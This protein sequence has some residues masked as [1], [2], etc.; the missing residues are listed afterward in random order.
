MLKKVLF[1]LTLT[2]FPLIS[3]AAAQ[4]Q[5]MLDNYSVAP[6][7]TVILQL[8][9]HQASDRDLRTIREPD[10]SP[11]KP[12]F[13][14][15]QQSRNQLSQIINGQI[16]NQ[17][18]W[19]YVLEPRKLGEIDI[20]PLR[21]KTS[22]GYLSSQ[23]LTIRVTQD[24]QKRDNTW[25][26]AFV[27]KE[28]PYL[29]EP[30]YYTLRV[31]HPATVKEFE[32]HPPT[33]NLLVEQLTDLHTQR[34][35]KNN[36]NLFVSEVTYLLTPLRSGRLDLS[37]GKMR[38]L[39]ASSQN[40]RNPG[41]M[42]FNFGFQQYKPIV[43]TSDPISLEVKPPPVNLPVWLPLKNLRVE[44]TWETALK[45]ATTVGTP[46]IRTLSLVGEGM[47]GQSFPDLT[48]LLNDN[49]NFRVRSP[50]PE[51]ERKL[52][53]DQKTPATFYTQTF[54]LIPLKTGQ[55]TLDAI[56]IPWWDVETDQLKWAEIPAQSFTVKDNPHHNLNT[57]ANTTNHASPSGSTTTT[58]NH[59]T[60]HPLQPLS[61]SLL[62]AATLA[63]FIGLIQIWW[64]RWHFY[65]TRHVNKTLNLKNFKNQI[66]HATDMKTL[67]ML[68]QNYAQT[69]WQL[70]AYTALS[71]I[72]LYLQKHYDA[73]E[74]I[75][76]QLQVL[77]AALYGNRPI[78]L[79]DWKQT[80]L[81]NF[82]QLR[83]KTSTTQAA[84]G[85]NTALNPT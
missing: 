80:F 62:M 24:Q 69:H 2:F 27:S 45:E 12:D 49:S 1:L 61:F 83:P 53:S 13:H 54:S 6:G 30:I 64:Q 9:L 73:A 79:D 42:N 56:K 19:T 39:K 59:I 26:E 14:I 17:V 15:H 55:L 21:L 34:F 10:V 44:H 82:Q 52:L 84:T 77:E 25:I 8:I 57:L 35:R 51:N 22:N 5:A 50:K 28:N 70:P 18:T 72:G 36:Q 58:V 7:E 33:D 38:A 31:Y 3:F 68:I 48:Q 60:A 29:H 16:S 85:Y 67:Q 78:V 32:A 71:T 37:G 74:G 81:Q 40:H 76:E 20:P 46:L 63:L 47:G 4:L 65:R 66:R 43:L 11:L 75:A 41:M 23:P